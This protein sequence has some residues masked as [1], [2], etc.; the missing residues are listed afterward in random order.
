MVVIV[1]CYEHLLHVIF[2][3]YHIIIYIRSKSVAL[4]RSRGLV[5][6][7]TYITL[8]ITVGLVATT[9]KLILV[10]ILKP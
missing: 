3:E 5:I 8:N 2:N 7:K 10:D 1:R 4:L 6:H 9:E